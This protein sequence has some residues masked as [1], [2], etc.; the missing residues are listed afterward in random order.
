[1]SIS[2]FKSDLKLGDMCVCMCVCER[3]QRERIYVR[4]DDSSAR[5]GQTKNEGNETR[6]HVDE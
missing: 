4:K 1:M 2:Y 6:T 3:Q 5:P